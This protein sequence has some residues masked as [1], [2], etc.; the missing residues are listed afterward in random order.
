MGSLF[1]SQTFWTILLIIASLVLLVLTFTL[2]LW[3]KYQDSAKNKPGS[4]LVLGE[5][6][7]S[8][9]KV[10]NW[11][12]QGREY[13]LLG[14]NLPPGTPIF[15][16]KPGKELATV[17]FGEN[18]S[19]KGFLVK[20]EDPDNPN[21]LKTSLEF[22]GDLSFAKYEWGKIKQGDIIATIQDR[23]IR[24]FGEYNLII[25]SFKGKFP[26]LETN[27]ELLDKLFKRL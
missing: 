3:R 22:I 9:F 19:L 24:N 27:T 4:C 17:D 5:K 26:D 25:R 14:F 12:Y 10:I 16:H 11:K 15:A 8:K 20:V 23:G 7:C 18:G 6:Y 13:K 21:D 2:P 1:K